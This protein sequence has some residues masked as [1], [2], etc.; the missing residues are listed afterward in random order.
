MTSGRVTSGHPEIYPCIKSGYFSGCPVS[1]LH[2]WI[3]K[4]HR[5]KAAGKA[6]KNDEHVYDELKR[7][8][9]ENARL[10]EEH[11]ILKKAAAFFARES[12]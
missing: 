9:K 11:S 5:P 10:K 3:A 12:L 1:F 4:Y 6:E 7:L 2:T 8:R